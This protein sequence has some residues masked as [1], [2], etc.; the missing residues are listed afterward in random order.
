MNDPTFSIRQ[1]TMEDARL[2]TD[3]LVEAANWHPERRRS[4]DVTLA[5]P[6]VSHYVAG[7]PRPGDLGSVAV[8]ADGSTIGACWLRLLTTADPG[9]G[10]VGNGVPEL[11]LGVNPVW[12]SRGVGRALL[13]AVVEQARE[14]GLAR[15]SL[16]CERANFAMNLYRGEGFV[17]VES[18]PDA[19]TMVR[20]L[21]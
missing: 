15:I 21:N 14:A 2:L 13:Q 18:G 6:A 9:Y 1:A 19:D 17:T 10:F 7:W 3:M 11:T 16:S 5:D 8:A 4:R 20:R 12:R